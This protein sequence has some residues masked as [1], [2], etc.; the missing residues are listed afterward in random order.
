MDPESYTHTLLYYSAGLP[1]LTSSWK[2][3]GAIACV[4]ALN[5]GSYG[6]IKLVE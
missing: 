3:F 1:A 5:L 6:H 2:E 4:F